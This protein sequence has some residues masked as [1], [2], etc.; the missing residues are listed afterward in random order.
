MLLLP[1]DNYYVQITSDIHSDL[2]QPS[3]KIISLFRVSLSRS[4]PNELIKRQTQKD[5]SI[6]A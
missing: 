4:A 5:G 1:A 2:I 6:K 3:I